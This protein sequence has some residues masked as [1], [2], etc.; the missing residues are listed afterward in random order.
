VRQMA[1][2]VGRPAASGGATKSG[3]RARAPSSWPSP[4]A[5]G[6]PVASGNQAYRNYPMRDPMHIGNFGM[7]TPYMKPG[8]R[9]GNHGGRARFRR[10]PGANSP[11]APDGPHRPHRPRHELDGPQLRHRPGPRWR[12]PRSHCRP[13]R[14][15]SNPCSPASA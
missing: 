2:R 13:C 5:S 7:G 11:E 8:V 6:L 10:T 1:D 4:T 3:N 15:R 12:C 9:S 14:R